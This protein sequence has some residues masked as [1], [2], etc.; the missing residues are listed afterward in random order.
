[1]RGKA[2]HEFPRRF[3]VAQALASVAVAALPLAI[4]ARAAHGVGTPAMVWVLALFGV[5]GVIWAEVVFWGLMAPI[6]GVWARRGDRPERIE[7]RRVPG[8]VWLDESLD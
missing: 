5:A 4:V 6:A 7:A 3:S 1:M 2:G 8:I